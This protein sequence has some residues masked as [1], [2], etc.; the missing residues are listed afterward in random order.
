MPDAPL[1]SAEWDAP[2][3]ADAD[4]LKTVDDLPPFV[5]A[6]YTFF[7]VDPGEHVDNAADTDSLAVLEK[8]VEG[9]NWDE[10]S[11]FYLTCDQ[12]IRPGDSLTRS[13]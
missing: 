6:G 12:R 9:L 4:H 5:D 3:G 7:T 2:W 10:L 8:K 1:K 11:A 13:R